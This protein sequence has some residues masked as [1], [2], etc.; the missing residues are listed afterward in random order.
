MSV[1]V[2]SG[3]AES[4]APRRS[5]RRTLDEG[6]VLGIG[7]IAV[8]AVLVLPPLLV[9]VRTSFVEFKQGFEAG[10]FTLQHYGNLLRGNRLGASALNSVIFS[11]AATAVSLL[12]GGALAW[13]VERTDVPLK[14]LAFLT[15]VISLG[16]PYILY[17]TGWLFLLG[18]SGPINR[19][20]IELTGSRTD[21]FEVSSLTGM[22]LI[23]GFLWSPLVFLLLSATFRAANAEMEEAARMSGAS[24][25]DTITRVSLKL[26]Q[27]AVI[28][29]ALFVFIRN[30]EAFEVPALVGIPG[31]VTV[32]TTE[33]YRGMKKMPPDIGFVSAYAVVM[34]AIIA[35]LLHF[36][37]KLSERAERFASITGKG[38]RPRPFRLGSA[39]W[40]GGGVVLCNFLIVLVLPLGAILWMS[41]TP[42]MQPIRSS[43]FK[44][45]TA[46]HFVHV[47]SDSYYRE[48]ALNTVIVAGAVA[49]LV[50]AL[51]FLTGWV[52]ARRKRGSRVID[53]LVTVP[54]VF[55]GIV[56]GIAMLQI[57]LNVP[58]PIYGT[59]SIIIVGFLIR[60]IPYG[61]RYSFSGVLQI[62]KELEQAASVSGA[63]VG[64]LLRKVVAPLL[65]PALA[66]AWIFV[67]LIAAKEMSMPL[68]LSGPKSQTIPVAMFDLWTSGQSGEVAALGLVWA[69]LMTL[70]SSCFYV[71][72]RSASAKTFGK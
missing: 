40:I 34:V 31:D 2:S 37:G 43:A 58:V 22:I 47:F 29:L 3:S 26:A 48:L 49:T 61:M 32:L 52:V 53:Q 23:E 63:S 21:L 20:W 5:R 65:A 69:T 35:V 60:Y 68:L 18:R 15:S 13:L 1:N 56:L 12:F 54:L 9:L 11:S 71:L 27:P 59:L 39:R 45:L 30:I 33:I 6:N 8:L 64:Q 17:V 62:H 51:T 10:G 36:Y 67:F 72:S 38:Y 19:M 57:A 55:P 70:L 4:A 46:E 50:V 24:V 41:I 66:S 42:F 44:S 25:F 7:L 14:P 16:T 28:A